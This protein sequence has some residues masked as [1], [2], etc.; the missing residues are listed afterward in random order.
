MMIAVSEDEREIFDAN[1]KREFK[2]FYENMQNT[3]GLHVFSKTEELDC[4]ALEEF[5]SLHGKKKNTDNIKK[6]ST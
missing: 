1:K 4:E 3:N 6:K 2:S 5:A